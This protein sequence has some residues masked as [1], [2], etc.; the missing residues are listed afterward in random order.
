MNENQVRRDWLFLNRLFHRWGPNYFWRATVIAELASGPAAAIGLY[1]VWVTVALTIEQVFRLILLLL[2]LVLVANGSALWYTRRMTR[3]AK[4]VLQFYRGQHS[5]ET[6]GR[7][8][9]EVTGFPARFAVFALVN[10]TVL[11]V[12]PAVLWIMVVWR[13]PL[14]VLPYLLIG[15]FIATIWISIYYYFALY[16][17]LWPVRQAMAP[18]L[19]SLQKRYL[20]TVSIQ[21]RMLVIYTALALTTVVMMGSIAF[22]KSQQAVAPG[23]N[24]VLVLQALRFHL[25]IIGL[26]VLLMTVGFSVLLTRALAT[27]IQHLTQV[28]D[29][30]ERGELHHRAELVSTD[31]TAFLTIAFNQMIGRLAELQ[32]SLE[33]RVAERTAELARRT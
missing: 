16:W 19:P 27:P 6:I 20:A 28:M 1:Y 2:L 32:A 9:R 31:E 15:S 24:P 14:R 23:A 5:E 3:T 26:L 18:R 4:T 33:Q 30:V 11:V 7:A 8:W 13:F 10:T 21:T 29:R 22:Q 17:F 25:P 12:A